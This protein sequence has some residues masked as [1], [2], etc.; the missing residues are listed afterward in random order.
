MVVIPK[1]H[2]EPKRIM[3]T[4]WSLFISLSP[5]WWVSFWSSG[6]WLPTNPGFS[7]TLWQPQ[8]KDGFILPNRVDKHQ[9]MILIG[10][11]SVQIPPVIFGPPKSALTSLGRSKSRIKP[12]RGRWKCVEGKLSSPT[13]KSNQTS[14]KYL[15]LITTA[16]IQSHAGPLLFLLYFDSSMSKE[17]LEGIPEALNLGDSE[18]V[19]AFKWRCRDGG[20]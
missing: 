5:T 10:P 7:H 18:A 19:L 3:G 20:T 9:W 14:N 11:G 15:P 17:W 1:T 8:L 4:S 13:H 16:R 12:E 2:G 6:S